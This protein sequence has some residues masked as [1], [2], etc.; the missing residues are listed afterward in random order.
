MTIGFGILWILTLTINRLAEHQLLFL[1]TYGLV[2]GNVLFPI[3]FYQG[4][5]KMQYSTSINLLGRVLYIILI[6]SFIHHRDDYLLVPVFNSAGIVTTGII[7]LWLA[8]KKFGVKFHIP[9]WQIIVTELKQ[10]FQFF[11]SRVSVSMYTSFN[12]L[13][14]GFVATDQ[15]VGYYAAAEKLFIAMRTA[16]YPLVTALYPY[17]ANRRQVGIFKKLF[18]PAV[19]GAIIAAVVIF[20]FSDVITELVFGAGFAPSASVLQLF[21]LIV[22]IVTASILLGYPFLAALGREKYANFSIAIGS[23][24]HLLLI[25]LLIPFMTM[26]RIVLVTMLTETIILAIRIYGVHKYHLWRTT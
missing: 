4:I 17:M 21:S 9:S 20:N 22:P 23:V 14:L 3:W 10:G 24:S 13:I 16:F 5:E 19:G 6:F 11:L 12:T 15:V 25:V 8:L 1:L 2:L 18:Y 26:H 7:C